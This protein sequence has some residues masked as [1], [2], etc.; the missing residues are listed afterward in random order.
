MSV[1]P[2]ENGYYVVIQSDPLDNAS[3]ISSPSRIFPSEDKVNHTVAP[4]FDQKHSNALKL[5]ASSLVAES[6]AATSDKNGIDA[7]PRQTDFKA[8][9]QEL[10]LACVI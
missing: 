7:R 3:L 1:W 5:R 4:V 10:S 6:L 8:G 9:S 2:T